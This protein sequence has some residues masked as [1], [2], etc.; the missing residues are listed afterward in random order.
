MRDNATLRKITI[1][2]QGKNEKVFSDSTDFVIETEQ[3][4]PKAGKVTQVSANAEHDCGRVFW[5]IGADE[6]RQPVFSCGKERCS[7]RRRRRGRAC[8]PCRG[9]EASH[10]SRRSP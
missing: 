6:N 8:H 1:G 3:K 5:R 7:G 2:C 4:K 9:R 10:G